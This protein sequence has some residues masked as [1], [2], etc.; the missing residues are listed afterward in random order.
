MNR[1]LRMAAVSAAFIAL[2][3]CATVS[4]R[5]APIV[6]RSERKADAPPAQSAPP[7]VGAREAREG[8]YVVQ[9]GDT[10]YSIALEFGHDY[11][12]LARWNSL[13]DASKLQVGQELRV[14]PPAGTGAQGAAAAVPVAPAAAADGPFQRD[15]RQEDGG[16]EHDDL[17]TG[18]GGDSCTGR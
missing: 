6:D 16:R 18:H 14:Q 11:R 10:L 9:R 4:L 2:A 8:R 13:E 5:E 12:D 3:G 1:W 15:Q 17:G 7:A